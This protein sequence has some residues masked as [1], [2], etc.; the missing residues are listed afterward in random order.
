MPR[1]GSENRILV[2]ARLPKSLLD[3]L[4]DRFDLTD[5]SNDPAGFLGAG[6]DLQRFEL[7]ATLGTSVL[8][9]E[10]IARLPSLKYL[11]H[12]GVGYDGIDIDALRE[13]G[14]LMTNTA[15]SNSSCVADFAM[16]LLTACV[17]EL[18][19]QDRFVRSG[20]WE[21]KR[22]RLRP[23]QPLGGRK[24]GIYGLGEIGRKIA[25]RAAAFEM[26]IGYCA[27]RPGRDDAYRFF[28]TSLSLAEWADHFVVAVKAT[29]ATEQTV[30]S[31]VLRALGPQGY[32]INVARGSVIAEPDLIAALADG[33]IAGAGLDVFASEPDIAPELKRFDNVI[34]SPHTAAN[35]DRA[36]METDDLFLANLDRYLA[37]LPP[38][39]VVC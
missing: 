32:V 36:W 31:A 2:L 23:S 37:G 29:A 39:N 15:G 3:I 5:A 16:T 35:T 20:A 19:A 14:V 10:L 30:D 28:P 34:L 33:T 12:Y 4:G 6:D 21:R 26:E 25:S 38:T 11:C 27:T 24:L 17:R 1:D 8:T 9:R 22:S 13:R 18:P 7:A